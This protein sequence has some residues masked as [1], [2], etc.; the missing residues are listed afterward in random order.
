MAVLV[1]LSRSLGDRVNGL[2]SVLQEPSGFENRTAIKFHRTILTVY[3]SLASGFS[4]GA[5]FNPLFKVLALEDALHVDA[6]GRDLIGVELA[7]FDQM[8]DLGT[9]DLSDSGHHGTTVARRV[10]TDQ[11]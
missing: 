7:D 4:H 10:A 8:L 6:G 1:S 9:G 3:C 11:T 2:A 5:L